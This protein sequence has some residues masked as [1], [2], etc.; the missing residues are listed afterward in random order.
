MAKDHGLCN[1]EAGIQVTQGGEL[2]LLLG[3]NHI[4][5]FDCIQRLLLALQ[6]DDVGFRD[7]ALCKPPYRAYALVLVALCGDHHVSLVQ[8]KHR[9]LHW[10]DH[11]VFG[12]PI[13]QHSI[14]K[15]AKYI[16]LDASFQLNMIINFDLRIK[17][18][19]LLNHLTDLKSQL[20][21]GSEA[22]ALKAT[23]VSTNSKEKLDKV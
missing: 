15:V 2:V 3:A 8:H 11:S 7:H 17:L 14:R 12:A 1:G 20:I 10:V 4:E 18:P 5:L 19:H 9:N 13:E 22:Q 23:T 16:F 21:C 6:S